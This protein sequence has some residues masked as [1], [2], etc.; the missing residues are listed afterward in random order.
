MKISSPTKNTRQ[1]APVRGAGFQRDIN[2]RPASICG[3]GPYEGRSGTQESWSNGGSGRRRARVLSPEEVLARE[4]AVRQEIVRRRGDGETLAQLAKRFR[5]TTDKVSRVLALQRFKLVQEFDLGFIPNEKFGRTSAAEERAIL[6]PVPENRQ[7]VRKVARPTG[8]PPYLASMYETPL[9][10]R[11]QEQ[12]LFRKMNYLKFKANELR[13]RLDARRP[14]VTLLDLIERYNKEAVAVKNDIVRANLRLVVSIAKRY[15]SGPGHLF[16]LI[17]DGNMSLIR[18]AE[19]FD[20]ARGFRFSTY[21]TWAIMKNFARTIPNELRQQTRFRTG[22]EERLLGIEDIRPDSTR[23]ESAQ[24][25]R[26][27]EISRILQHLDERERQIIQHRFGLDRNHDPMT[28]KEVG[29]VMGVT[30]E[31]IRQLEARAMAKLR[32]AVGEEKVEAPEGE[33]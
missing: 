14:R 6:G 21:A 26:Q 13:G 25:E 10:T 32:N 18:A 2:G 28:L 27:M 9:L 3:T 1:L 12:H 24:T 20:F 5:C 15:A 11:D 23:R 19:K 31:R 30:K 4:E 29:R 33:D 8:L 7:P 22:G 17:S 16:E